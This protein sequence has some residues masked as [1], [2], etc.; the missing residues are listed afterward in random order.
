L[1]SSHA[2]EERQERQ[3]RVAGQVRRGARPTDPGNR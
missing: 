3:E 1:I 2:A